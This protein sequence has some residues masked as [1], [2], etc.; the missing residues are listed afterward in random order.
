MK[1]EM[2]RFHRAPGVHGGGLV[3]WAA[4]EETCYGGV[5]NDG[6]PWKV[7]DCLQ[8]RG[9]QSVSFA[10][11]ISSERNPPSAIIVTLGQT[12]T[13][14]KVGLLQTHWGRG[15]PEWMPITRDDFLA[16]YR[17]VLL[18]VAEQI[19]SALNVKSRT[20]SPADTPDGLK[21]QFAELEARLSRVE[22]TLAIKR[23]E[24]GEVA[25]AWCGTA[26]PG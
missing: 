11:V 21:D 5:M 4:L 13:E 9:S 6:G 1:P 24:L 7:G 3:P 26:R 14:I 15:A 12:W 16:S 20:E 10:L 18:D 19:H 2:G 23:L 25:R 22:V 8:Y 17:K